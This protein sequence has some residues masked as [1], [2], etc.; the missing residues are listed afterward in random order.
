MTETLE[1]HTNP[2]LPSKSFLT[3]ALFQ[4]SGDKTIKIWTEKK[5]ED[6]TRNTEGHTDSKKSPSWTAALF[7]ELGHH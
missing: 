3:A 7:Q 5:E 2:V 4:G 6:I 1:G